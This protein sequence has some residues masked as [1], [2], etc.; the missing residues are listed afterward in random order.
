MDRSTNSDIKL[1]AA[2][3]AGSEAEASSD[4]ANLSVYRNI[5]H[6]PLV[7]SYRCGRALMKSCSFDSEEEFRN[8]LNGELTRILTGSPVDTKDSST[9]EQF[10]CYLQQKDP[11]NLGDIDLFREWTEWLALL[12]SGS[13]LVQHSVE[14]CLTIAVAL[15][16]SQTVASFLSD[17]KG[18]TQSNV[19]QAARD[20]HTF[21]AW[22]RN[23]VAFGMANPAT[24]V[25]A[26]ITQGDASAIKTWRQ[27]LN[28]F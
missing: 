9:L 15:A 20:L 23:Q 8:K 12:R 28:K 3:V 2:W 17:S 11:I 13:T 14:T 16:S 26:A 25:I 24:P 27:E 10:A 21:Y 18:M 4:F 1:T 22:L 6:L 5:H 19:V 7:V